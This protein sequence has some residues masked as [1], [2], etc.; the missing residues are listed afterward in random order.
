LK[1]KAK[2]IHLFY[3]LF[4]GLKVNGRY[5]SLR[6]GVGMRREGKEGLK[7]KGGSMRGEYKERRERKKY[8]SRQKEIVGKRASEFNNW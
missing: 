3:T 4:R 5:E 7:K 2:I 6:D 1:N 8:D